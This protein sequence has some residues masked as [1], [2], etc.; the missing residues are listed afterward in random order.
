MERGWIIRF[1]MPILPSINFPL[2]C[3]IGNL[4]LAHGKIVPDPLAIA[5]Q[6][7]DSLKSPAHPKPVLLGYTQLPGNHEVIIGDCSAGRRAGND[8]QV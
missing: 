1:L 8:K 4:D 6:P 2:I 7:A 5:L 3:F